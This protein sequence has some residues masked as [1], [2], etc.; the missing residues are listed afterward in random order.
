MD[1]IEKYYPDVQNELNQAQ[2]YYDRH[3]GISYITMFMWYHLALA[4]I[5]LL[6]H[7]TMTVGNLKD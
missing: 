6:A 1:T 3:N 7:L 4:A 5:K 2:D